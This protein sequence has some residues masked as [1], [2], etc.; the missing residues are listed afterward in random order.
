[1]LT[2]ERA[3]IAPSVAGSR[4]G[5]I[6]RLVRA[7]SASLGEA[8]D[9]VRHDRLVTRL[10]IAPRERAADYPRTALKDHSSRRHLVREM[11]GAL[12]FRSL[13][14]PGRVRR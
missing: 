1:M 12:A 10:R 4:S 13:Y 11:E 6:G 5:S 7:W 2:H 9:E 3:I 14:R 8:T